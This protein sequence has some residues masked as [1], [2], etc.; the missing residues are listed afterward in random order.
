[1]SSR[2]DARFSRRLNDMQ[3]FTQIAGG[4]TTEKGSRDLGIAEGWGK[5]GECL[6]R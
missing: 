2:H 4:V 5:G 1:M 3:V 6:M